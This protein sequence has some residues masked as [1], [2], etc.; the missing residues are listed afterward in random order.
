MA[1][2]ESH[3]SFSVF[4][5]LGYAFAGLLLFGIGPEQVVLALAIIVIAGIL[6]DID[7][8]G[9]APVRELSSILAAIAPVA[10]MNLVPYFRE[11][12]IS[13]IALL[14]ILCYLVTRVFIMRAVQRFC[15][16]RGMLH[17]IPAALLTFQITYL[18][19]WDL[20]LRPRLFVACA[21]LLGFLSHLILDATT[22]V[23]LVGK[24]MGSAEKKP[25]V[26]KV[27][28]PTSGVT[29]FLYFSVF[30]LGWLVAQD[31]YPNL[32]L[33]FGFSY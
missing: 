15:E 23:D 33:S 26:L 5:G 10:L 29:V 11:G 31:M 18:I 8:K 20:T 12:G 32:R 7:A 13:R 17:S 30:V 16:R 19:F 6:P 28:A 25:A 22:N 2:Y 4:L 27:L 14:I 21:A 1:Q 24:A 9:G 3:I